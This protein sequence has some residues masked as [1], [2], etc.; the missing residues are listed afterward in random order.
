MNESAERISR[1][2]VTPSTDGLRDALTRQGLVGP[3]RQKLENTKF[4]Y[5]EAQG[6]LAPFGRIRPGV[7]YAIAEFKTATAGA[8][9]DIVDVT[10]V[11][12]ADFDG[13]F[14]RFGIQ[15]DRII[16]RRR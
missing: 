4:Y 2:G 13:L 16:R 14:G 9:L 5:R 12:V 8:P 7:H 11:D 3:G 1:D 15:H 6:A 10:D